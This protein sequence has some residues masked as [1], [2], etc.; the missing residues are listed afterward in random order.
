MKKFYFLSLMLALALQATAQVW[1]GAASAT[2]TNGDGSENNPY[3]IETPAQ[4]VYLSAQVGSGN[5][6]AG[7]YF[8]Q[9]N[10][11]NM[12]DKEFPVIGKYD[13]STDS[14]TQQTVDNSCY[15]KGTNHR[16]SAYYE[17]T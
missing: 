16:P 17:S 3:L 6:F 15:F 2:W 1:D 14:Q 12:G 10:D 13:K 11:L 7:K 9:M 8:R 4:L 5:T